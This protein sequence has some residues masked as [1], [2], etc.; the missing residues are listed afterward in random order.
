MFIFSPP[1][2]FFHMFKAATKVQNRLNPPGEPNN[3]FILH[4][5]GYKPHLTL[6]FFL[7]YKTTLLFQAHYQ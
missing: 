4:T 7:P 1:V 2:F 6:L 5:S 3:L